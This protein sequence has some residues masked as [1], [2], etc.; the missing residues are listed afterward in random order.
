MKD[1]LS[2]S[3]FISKIIENGSNGLFNIYGKLELN[4]KKYIFCQWLI[5]W[6]LYVKFCYLKMNYLYQLSLIWIKFRLYLIYLK[7]QK[8]IHIIRLTS[9]ILNIHF[10][11]ENNFANS[12]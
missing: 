5:N 9:I 10:K 11:F 3:W 7:L 2:K 8:W 6:I 4:I 12:I 1:I